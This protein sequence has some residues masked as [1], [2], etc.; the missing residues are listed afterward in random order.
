MYITAAS[1]ISAQQPM[2][3]EWLSDPK[4]Y[5]AREYVRAVDPDF[6][7]WIAP[8][9]AR[10]MSP[11]IK[12]AIAT[13]KDALR[14]GGIEVPDAVISGTGLG[15]VENTEKFLD[16][17][18][19]SGEQFLQ[20]THF[21][22]S[23]HN[24]VSSQIA[25]LLKCHGYNNTYVH[26]G[27]S[28]E[29]ALL[30]AYLLFKLGKIDSALVGGH[31][32]LTPDYHKML[33]K[34][35][36]WR[37]NAFAS[38][39]STSFLLTKQNGGNALCEIKSVEIL[40]NPCDIASYCEKYNVDAVMSGVSGDKQSDSLYDAIIAKYSNQSTSFYTFKDVCG[41]YFTASAFGL[42]AATCKMSERE[43][44]TMLFVNHYK[45]EDYSLILL[46]RC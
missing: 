45:G 30:D 20:P 8:M 24:T 31:D 5:S 23:T 17:M 6:K 2:C 14:K 29:S 25:L 39:G 9:A 28:F 38:E 7:E 22:Q 12:R 21:I 44:Q 3:E 35:D 11:I 36:F 4:Q 18:V 37:D 10:R 46:Q 16:A 27:V 33:Q 40:H 15:C 41:E 42:Y 43:H 32:E 34:V 13:S 26:R 1:H 19:R